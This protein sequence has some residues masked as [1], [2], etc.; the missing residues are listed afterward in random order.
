MRIAFLNRGRET[1]PG[2]D[3]I[4]L[5]ETMAALRR[6]GVECVETGWDVEAIKS[7]NFDLCHMFHCNFDWSWGNYQAIKA[8]GKKYVL[9]PIWY[10]GL[11]SGVTKDQVEEIFSNTSTVLPFSRRERDDIYYPMDYKSPFGKRMFPDTLDIQCRNVRIIPNGTSRD[12][13]H[14]DGGRGRLFV[15]TVAAREGDKNVDKVSKA[16]RIIGVE[17]RNCY[18][19]PHHNMPDYYATA[20]VFVNASESERMSLTIGEALC[21]GC[22]VLATKENRGNEH[23]GTGLYTFDPKESVEVLA[24]RIRT[25]YECSD[26]DWDWSPNIRARKLT[27]DLTAAMLK[28]VYEEVLA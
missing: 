24:E 20:R 15:W 5:D 14:Y 25:V 22:R 3:V 4:A 2:G 7:G 8:A 12:F 11:F 28:Q 10:P 23:Y 13:H 17:H 27:W 1:H 9:T 16:C 26:D 21:A 19:A 18:D 6:L